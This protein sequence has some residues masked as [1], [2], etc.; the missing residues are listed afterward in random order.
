MRISTKLAAVVLAVFVI[1][2]A[3]AGLAVDRLRHVALMSVEA[4]ARSLGTTFANM[5]AYQG[6][7]G[8][9]A[10]RPAQFQRITDFIGVREKRDL[11]IIG[12][13]LVD[14]ADVVREDIGKP[15]EPGARRDSIARTLKDGE[16]RLITEPATGQNAAMRQ[17][18]VPIYDAKQ[19]IIA[20]LVYEYT[21]LYNELLSR[22]ENSLRGV[23][24]AALA[25]LLLALGCAAFIARSV[26]VPLAQ[27]R[28]AATMLSLGRR[29]VTVD[30]RS[31]DE[32]GELARVF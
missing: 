22:A 9:V 24:A 29:D 27:L 23:V 30:A 18:V 4:E 5:V 28:D 31:N 13:D 1:V 10:D 14:I 16:A 25:G 32:I 17:V 11:E 12:P 26:S 15:L 6:S 2:A 19:Q 20:A 3:V 21:P 7:D 8:S